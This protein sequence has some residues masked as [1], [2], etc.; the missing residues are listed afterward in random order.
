MN[1]STPDTSSSR[2]DKSNGDSTRS[3]SREQL[4][5]AAREAASGA[6]RQAESVYRDV[7][8]GAAATADEASDAMKDA[9]SRLDESGHET[10]GKATA[11][12]AD[13]AR[14]FSSYL[15]SRRLEDF[16]RDAQRLA[17]RNPALFIAGGVALGFA[18]SR[19]FK[20]GSSGTST[21][22]KFS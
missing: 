13:Q 17:Q 19:F 18:L 7:S 3:E 10:L 11:A 20:A 14:R 5:S 8:S 15:E 21:R 6:K 1:P 9:A 22:R 4:G 2:A 16:V 12:L